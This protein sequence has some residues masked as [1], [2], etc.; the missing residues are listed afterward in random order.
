LDSNSDST[1]YPFLAYQL[2]KSFLISLSR[3]L[4]D[5]QRHGRIFF[6]LQ[7][8]ADQPI[9]EI[10]LVEAL[11]RTTDSVRV[12]GPEPRRVRCQHFVDE[13]DVVGGFIEPEFELGVGEDDAS[14]FG[15]AACLR[16]CQFCGMIGG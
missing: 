8:L 4:H 16:G 11:L 3:L 5:L 10:L 15:V 13:D 9:A 12:L 1:I 2:L 14:S 7:T 6:P